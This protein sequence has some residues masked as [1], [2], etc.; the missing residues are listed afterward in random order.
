VRAHDA[1]VVPGELVCG[2]DTDGALVGCDGF[3]PA[4]GLVEAHA[5]FVPELG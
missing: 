4:T 3:R 1:E 5:A 2:I